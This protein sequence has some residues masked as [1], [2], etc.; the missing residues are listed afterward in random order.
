M[1]GIYHP[2]ACAY[3]RGGRKENVDDRVQPLY[4]FVVG[5]HSLL[6]LFSLRTKELESGSGRLAGLQLGHQ[7]MGDK[8]FLGLLFI[9]FQRSFK[10]G[11]QIGRR[12]TWISG[13]YLR[14]VKR[15]LSSEF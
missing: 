2:N 3:D 9:L 1:N 11:L 4:Q 12:G 14:H 6:D 7:R 8:A 5:R 10:D 15:W 13:S